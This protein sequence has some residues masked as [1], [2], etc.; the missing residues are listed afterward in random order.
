MWSLPGAAYNN[1][2]PL[3]YSIVDKRTELAITPEV[4]PQHG[5]DQGSEPVTL[6]AEGTKNEDWLRDFNGDLSTS[7]LSHPVSKSLLQNY[8]CLDYDLSVGSELQL[9]MD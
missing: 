7:T 9:F 1:Q 2:R 3:G 5:S 8:K 6:A 4:E